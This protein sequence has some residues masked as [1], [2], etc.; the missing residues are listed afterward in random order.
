LEANHQGPS[1]EAIQHN[2]GMLAEMQ[3]DQQGAAASAWMPSCDDD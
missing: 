3:I 1:G 2:N